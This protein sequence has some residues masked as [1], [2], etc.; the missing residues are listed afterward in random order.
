MSNPPD[1]NEYIRLF[2]QIQQQQQQ[3]QGSAPPLQ[4][5]FTAPSANDGAGALGN[6]GMTTMAAGAFSSASH[7]S[8]NTGGDSLTLAQAAARTAAPD[9][10]DTVVTRQQQ[11]LHAA[12]LLSTVN[13][14]LAQTAVQQAMALGPLPN[15]F[16]SSLIQP[17]HQG[18]LQQ[19]NG[20][21]EVSLNRLLSD[22]ITF[23]FSITVLFLFT[24]CHESAKPP[25]FI[26]RF[27][28]YCQEVVLFL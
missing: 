21:D 20:Q 28:N 18:Q 1:P 27:Q 16:L 5:L 25:C 6:L 4:G 10:N 14:S 15:A 7:Q 12:K 8:A 24:A 19:P 22:F 3:Q 13:K 9:A 26:F 11:L 23:S 17:Q 2:L